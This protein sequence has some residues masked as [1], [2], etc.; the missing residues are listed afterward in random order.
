MKAPGRLETVIT[1]GFGV[2]GPAGFAEIP[3]TA[4]GSQYCQ[5]LLFTFV[6]V[7]AVLM[8]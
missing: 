8:R 3:W 1:D 5:V 6:T 4:P 2:N 7:V